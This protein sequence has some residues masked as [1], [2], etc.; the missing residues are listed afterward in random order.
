ME[1]ESKELQEK[2]DKLNQEIK[3]KDKLSDK[4]KEKIK[5]LEEKIDKLKENLKRAKTIRIYRRILKRRLR[6]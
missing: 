3:D 6:S 2:L 5:D 1:K 4:Q